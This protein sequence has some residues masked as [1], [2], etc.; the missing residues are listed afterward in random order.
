MEVGD[1]QDS[2]LTAAALWSAKDIEFGNENINSIPLYYRVCQAFSQ[3]YRK[4]EMF[5]QRAALQLH[6]KLIY[7]V[8]WWQQNKDWIE[9]A[10]TVFFSG[11]LVT[12]VLSVVSHT[13]TAGGNLIL[14][15][16]QHRSNRTR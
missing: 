8:E 13:L 16:A 5:K 9:D 10:F 6:G 14:Q 15:N 3:R 7:L 12:N 4:F 2:Q 1:K 11:L